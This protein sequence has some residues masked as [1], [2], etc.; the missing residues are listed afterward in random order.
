MTTLGEPQTMTEPRTVTL[1]E[2][3]ESLILKFPGTPAYALSPNSRKHW[4]VKA[5]ESKA[6]KWTVKATWM[7]EERESVSGPVTIT[8]GIHL[9]R[10]R[11][12]MD[13]DNA[14]ATL[15]PYMDGLVECG[16]IEG[17]TPDIVT[18]IKIWQFLF[19]VDHPIEGGEIDCIIDPAR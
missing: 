15:K 14:T 17:D 7:E 18:D 1:T 10:R 11:K 16:I 2:A 5:R 13:K 3:R 9:A 19:K 6:A 12:F 8:W 4:A